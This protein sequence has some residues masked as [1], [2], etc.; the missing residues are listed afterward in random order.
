MRA[1]DVIAK[2]RDGQALTADEIAWFVR[3]VVGGTVAD[4]Q[5]SA[6]L[7]AVYLRGMDAGE[8]V[9]LTRAMAESGRILDLGP[10]RERAVDK[11]STGGV[12]DKTSLIVGPLAAACGVIVPKMSG[13][14]LGITGGTL[15][16][17]ESIPGFQVHLSQTEFLQQ[18]S[19]IGIAIVGQSADLA[20]AD[21]VLYALRDV[22]ATVGSLPL[23]VS[24]ILSKKIAGGAPRIVLDVKAGRGAFMAS[25]EA[26]REL[27]RSLVEVGT[28]ADRR[29]VAYVTEMDQPLGQAVGNALEIREAIRTLQGWGPSDLTELALTLAAEMIVLAGLA[30]NQRAGRRRAAEA[31]ASGDALAR[32]RALIM[33]QGGDPGV[34]EAPELLPTAPITAA[35]RSPSAGYVASIDAGRVGAAMIALGAGRATKL[36]QV[37]HAVGAIF[38]RKVGAAVEPGDVLC[39]L[40]L[41]SAEQ[42]PTATEAILSAYRFSSGPVEVPP[43]IRERIAG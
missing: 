4:Y 8:T 35:V 28:A 7:M 34:V 24:S 14:G 10:L 21:G 29:I 3:G 15:D 41:R 33:A 36:D 2:K 1:V 31:L 9:A 22:T 18:I 30:P 40:H 5:A 32:L 42:L 19:E 12:G 20:P 16:K 6:W 37:D 43:I 39:T 11:H 26:A 17:L 25:P 13:R 38:E 23:I 27:A